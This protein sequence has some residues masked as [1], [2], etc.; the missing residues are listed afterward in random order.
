MM[1]RPELYV[2]TILADVVDLVFGLDIAM[3]GHSQIDAHSGAVDRFQVYCGIGK[4]FARAVNGH[5][6]GS[7]AAAAFLFL[8]VFQF[9]K[10]TDPGQDLSHVPGFEVLY[11]RNPV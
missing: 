7:G 8:L 2:V 1:V 4:G 5:G 11:S 3:L 9:I 6:P 10:I